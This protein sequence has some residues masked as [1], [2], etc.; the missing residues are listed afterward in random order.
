RD[1]DDLWWGLRVRER[2]SVSAADIVSVVD[3]VDD[4]GSW[5]RSELSVDGGVLLRG[6]LCGGSLVIVAHHLVVVGVS[7]VG[8]GQ[9]LGAA[10]GAV[11]GGGRVEL[12]PVGPSWRRWA[13]LLVEQANS[14]TRMRELATWKSILAEPEPLLG[15]RAL[16][17]AVDVVATAGSLT[18]SLSEE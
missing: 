14:A 9:V 10:W 4:A 15:R 12:A 7:W 8:L 6:G 16:D 3:N 1:E 18:V 2:G 11:G 13:G 17:P 5:A